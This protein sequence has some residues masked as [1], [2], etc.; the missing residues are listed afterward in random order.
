MMNIQPVMDD[1]P[2]LRYQLRLGY[3]SHFFGKVGLKP[4][5]MLTLINGV[6][7]DS[8]NKVLSLARWLAFADDLDITI[9]RGGEPMSF[10]Y[11]FK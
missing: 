5:D 11:K 4:N 8:P 2:M 1:E 3:I 7:L 9:D 10:R 6:K